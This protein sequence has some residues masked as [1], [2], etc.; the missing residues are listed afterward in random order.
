MKPLAGIG[1]VLLLLGIIGLAMPFFTTQDTH[2][3][4]K[5]GSLSVQNTQQ[6]THVIPVQV[7]IGAVVIGIVML[8]AGVVSGRAR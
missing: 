7:S 5:L 3:V 4:A 8:G 2:Q 1:A 6:T